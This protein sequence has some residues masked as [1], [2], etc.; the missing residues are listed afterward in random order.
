MHAPR[1]SVPRFAA[2]AGLVVDDELLLEPLAQL[3]PESCA[4][5]HVGG[6]AGGEGHHPRAPAS[7]ATPCAKT[8]PLAAITPM[9]PNRV[10]RSI[11][12]MVPVASFPL[13]NRD[14]SR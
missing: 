11:V 1:F 9:S 13:A 12:C 7:L 6:A 4:R 5:E 10:W 2:G 14:Y 3:L 8:L